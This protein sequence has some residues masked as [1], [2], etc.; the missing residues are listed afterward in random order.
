MSSLAV[1]ASRIRVCHLS[2][3]LSPDVSLLRSEE[4]PSEGEEEGR[5]LLPRKKV[6]DTTW[7]EISPSF[8]RRKEFLL[9][10]KEPL[11]STAKKSHS[12]AEP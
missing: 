7:K 4:A 9:K 6:E 1:K 10:E 8:A 12:T 2:L 11:P 5:R 3:T